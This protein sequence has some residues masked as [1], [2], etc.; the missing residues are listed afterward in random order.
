[1][2]AHLIREPYLA[3]YANP[4]LRLLPKWTQRR[5]ERTGLDGDAAAVPRSG[6]VRGISTRSRPG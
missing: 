4:S 2:A 5:I 1:M 6:P 3:D